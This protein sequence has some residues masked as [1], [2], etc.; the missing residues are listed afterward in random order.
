MAHLTHEMDSAVRTARGE[1]QAEGRRAVAELQGRFEA[2]R[3]EAATD[4]AQS[5]GATKS[6]AEALRMVHDTTAVRPNI[7]N[8][9]N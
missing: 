2:A 4:V 5:R 6:M 8:L 9:I 1:A 7:D 3:R